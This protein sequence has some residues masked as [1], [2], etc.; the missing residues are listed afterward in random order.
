M[1]APEHLATTAVAI[2]DSVLVHE[3]V[4]VDFGGV[5]RPGSYDAGEVFAAARPKLE[6]A[7]A[8]G[9]RRLLECTPHHLGRDPRL[10]A[11]L[12]DATGVEIWTNTGIYGAASRVGVPAYA[13][14]LSAEDLARRFVDEH[15][16]G[17]DGVRPRFVKTAV[18]D[19]K[20]EDLDRKL[21]RAAALAARETG[22]TV[23][24]HTTAGIAAVEQLAIFDEV[25]VPASQ[26]VWVHAHAEEDP[27]YHEQVARAGAWV[28]FDG[29]RPGE[30]EWQRTCVE[31]LAAAGLLG[32]TLIA[33][34]SG[35]YHVGE[36]DGGEFL[37]Y[38]CVYT[39]LLPTLDPAWRRT[40][41]VE[42][43]R[44]AFGR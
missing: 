8:L 37:G 36:P 9:C 12:A 17:I 7:Y 3:H 21:V 16:N 10:L 29:L 27:A 6:E 42:N 38:D 25:G 32:R 2:E 1:T 31:R 13:R 34:D 20:L 18:R 5:L 11:R 15:A 43:P 26:F 28:E 4:L 35:W 23:A 39:E 33:N 24:S 19:G 30:T 40:L 41:M 14:E 44:A 22:L